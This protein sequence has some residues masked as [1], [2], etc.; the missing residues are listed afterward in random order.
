M[1]FDQVVALMTMNGSI[2]A[3]PSTTKATRTNFPAYLQSHR[4]WR[5]FCM[6]RNLCDFAVSCWKERCMP[7][8]NN[9]EF[10]KCWLAFDFRIY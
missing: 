6:E 3:C 8:N 9:Y 5:A 10:A 1:N 7:P 4:A 2:A